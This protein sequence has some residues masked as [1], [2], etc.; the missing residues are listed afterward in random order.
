MMQ[1]CLHNIENESF[2]SAEHD[3]YVLTRF[4][5][6]DSDHREYV[7]CGQSANTDRPGCISSDLVPEVFMGHCRGWNLCD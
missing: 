1:A 5:C 6:M 4:E 3:N 2:C 7:L